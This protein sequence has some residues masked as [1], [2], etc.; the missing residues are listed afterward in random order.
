MVA[1]DAVLRLPAGWLYYYYHYDA[2][3]R[4]ILTAGVL[5]SMLLI[6]AL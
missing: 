2:R 6:I 3:Q 4:D 1:P 5:A